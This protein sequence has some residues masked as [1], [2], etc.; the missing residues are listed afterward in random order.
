[1]QFTLLVVTLGAAAAM[2]LPPPCGTALR[3]GTVASPRAAVNGCDRGADDDDE[4]LDPSVD[5]PEGASLEDIR[6]KGPG[7]LLSGLPWWAP[8]A[9][10][11]L[12]APNVLPP[13]MLPDDI[14]AAPTA[15]EERQLL[16]EER[17][18]VSDSVERELYGR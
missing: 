13:D 16:R 15:R 6:P 12:L 3:V 5:I 1:M 11:W 14:F 2:Q 10:G 7:A 8:L 17:A 4:R 9:I 18:I